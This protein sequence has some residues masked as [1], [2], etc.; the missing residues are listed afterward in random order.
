ML[1][2]RASIDVFSLS[3]FLS[4]TIN[5]F[6]IMSYPNTLKNRSSDGVFHGASNG[7]IYQVCQTIIKTQ[8]SK[9]F[10]EKWNICPNILT[11]WNF[12][13]ILF[14]KMILIVIFL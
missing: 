2:P 6:L 8:R 13:K 7:N 9:N 3:H 1:F 5:N 10:F 14:Q 11:N 12:L 4:F